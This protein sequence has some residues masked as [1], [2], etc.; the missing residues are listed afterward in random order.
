MFVCLTM[1]IKNS[2]P[3]IQEVLK[4]WEHAVNGFCILD[5]GSTDDTIQ[6]I[7][8]LK[9]K[10]LKLFEHEFEGFSKSRNRCIKLAEKNFK[11]DFYI[12]IDD[13]YALVDSE[14]SPLVQQLQLSKAYGHKLLAYDVKR[15]DTLHP[16]KM[17]FTKGHRYVGDIHEDIP[18]QNDIL[19]VGAYV[20]DLVPES[21]LKRTKERMLRDVEI[22][23]KDPQN[24]RNV[25]FMGVSY[26][27]AGQF[28][29][30][31]YWFKKRLEFP[32]DECTTQVYLYLIELY[33]ESKNYKKCLNYCIDFI[34]KYP[35]DPRFPEFLLLLYYLT[36]DKNAIKGAYDIVK[37]NNFKAPRCTYT[38]NTRIY[39]EIIKNEYDKSIAV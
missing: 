35:N 33:R 37:E 19:I 25:Y 2:G 15:S 6:L 29:N 26:F 21:H 7:K 31:T 32:Y 34:K 27:V 30:A 8:D 4:S 9:L 5:T 36:Q 20:K 22:L 11:A 12:M 13:S 10:N 18:Q 23:K 28:D 38:I 14:E 3:I 39:E 1:I 16:R 17:I 24:P